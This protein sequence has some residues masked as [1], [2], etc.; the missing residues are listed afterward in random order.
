MTIGNP[1]VSSTSGESFVITDGDDLYRVERP[2]SQLQNDVETDAIC[3][4]ALTTSGDVY[5]LRR[6]APHILIF[7]ATGALKS[8]IEHRKLTSGHGLFIDANDRVFVTTYDA[9]QVLCF[10]KSGSLILELGEF[11][12]PSWGSLFN[13]PTDVAVSADGKIFVADGYGNSKVHR[14]SAEGRPEISWGRPGKDQGEFGVPHALC[15][16]KAGNLLVA[17]RENNRLQ[18]FDLDGKYLDEWH[19]FY[20]PMGIWEDSAG[21]I[22][23]TEQ[24]P[25]LTKLSASG[26]IIGRCSG[27]SQYP[28]DIWG[29]KAGNLWIAEINPSNLTK[30]CL[31]DDER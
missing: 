19:G 3:A 28:H 8:T 12:R 9:H 6:K 18:L 7:N 26:Q 29:D 17:D 22:F 16:T 15:I 25:R 2:W 27:F 1:I 23:V 11:N 24:T 5:C 13:H 21:C 20:R 10:S 30:L 31:V 14:F 4:V